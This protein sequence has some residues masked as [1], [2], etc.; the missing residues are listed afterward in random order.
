L[1][2]KE[3]SYVLIETSKVLHFPE[4][5]NDKQQEVAIFT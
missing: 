1:K 3:F 5:G 2:Q 4:A